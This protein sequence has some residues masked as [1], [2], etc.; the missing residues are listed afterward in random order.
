[1]SM[2]DSFCPGCLYSG[3]SHLETC[4]EALHNKYREPQCVLSEA[5]PV[6]I[7]RLCQVTI[8]DNEARCSDA[9]VEGIYH[10]LCFVSNKAERLSKALKQIVLIREEY[11]STILPM[12]LS[13]AIG[14]A[15]GLLEEY[16]EHIE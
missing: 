3:H 11:I 10:P 15:K 7:C 1:M 5:K 9:S 8:W 14:L 6:G 4:K 16:N 12:R 2:H 13:A